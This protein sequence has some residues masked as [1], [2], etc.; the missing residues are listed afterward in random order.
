MH[1]SQ[2]KN[3]VARR[4]RALCAAAGVEWDEDGSLKKEWEDVDT[5]L[6]VT[7]KRQGVWQ[8][9]V[10]AETGGVY[11]WNT[12]TDQTTWTRPPELMRVSKAQETKRFQVCLS[13][14]CLHSY[15]P[16]QRRLTRSSSA[17][18]YLQSYAKYSCSF[19]AQPHAKLR[20]YAT[21]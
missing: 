4:L 3:R 8:G 1:Q 20:R 7:G 12:I 9:L 21:H 11:Y 10:D 2:Q 14:T 16:F 17:V 5:S 18:W 19:P 15:A 6:V 13:V